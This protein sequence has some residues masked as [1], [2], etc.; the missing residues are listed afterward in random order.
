MKDILDGLRNTYKTP[1]ETFTFIGLKDVPVQYSEGDDTL[2]VG[3]KPFVECVGLKWKNIGRQK[4]VKEF[5]KRIETWDNGRRRVDCYVDVSTLSSILFGFKVW[6]RK[7]M[8]SDSLAKLE[9]W[10][11]KLD[12]GLTCE[13]VKYL[14]KS[15]FFAT[16]A[17]G[18][19]MAFETLDKK[20]KGMIE[21]LASQRDGFQ[22][23]TADYADIIFAFMRLNKQ[24]VDM[25]EEG[26]DKMN[27]D[28]ME[29]LSS[30]ISQQEYEQ[31]LRM[32][33]VNDLIYSKEYVD[34]TGKCPPIFSIDIELM[35]K[36]RL[37]QIEGHDEDTQP[38]YTGGLVDSNGRP[39]PKDKDDK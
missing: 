26:I 17:Y 39:L 33:K 35:R 13:Y 21:D 3:L 28:L 30:I 37:L 1:R 16:I 38:L 32:G 23:L 8:S 2:Y 29:S 4:R 6:Y 36:H 7:S 14:I 18:Y 31:L 24:F 27:I 20:F 19:K 5:V 10:I 22:T 11:E 15:N 12:K 25:E 34:F 9:E